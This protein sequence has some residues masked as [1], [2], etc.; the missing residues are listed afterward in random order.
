MCYMIYS[1]KISVSLYD[2]N[3]G[4]ISTLSTAINIFKNKDIKNNKTNKGYFIEINEGVYNENKQ[5]ELIENME[6]MGMGID[7]TIINFNIKSESQL[8]YIICLA[9]NIKISN[10][11]IKYNIDENILNYLIIMIKCIIEFVKNIMIQL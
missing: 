1:N 5:L 6:I 9:S 7:K 10:L 11:T 2:E 3:D 8:K 4:N